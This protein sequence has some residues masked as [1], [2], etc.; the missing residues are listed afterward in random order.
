MPGRE[1][2]VRT[3]TPS[4]QPPAGDNVVGAIQPFGKDCKRIRERIR[5]ESTKPAGRGGLWDG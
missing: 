5:A 1:S 2:P 4:V 3:S